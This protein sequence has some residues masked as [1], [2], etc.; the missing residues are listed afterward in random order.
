MTWASLD[1]VKDAAASWSDIIINC[2]S[3]GHNWVAQTVVRHRTWYEISQRCARG[4]GCE[5][6]ST[7]NLSGYQISGWRMA[8]PPDYLLHQKG[9][10]GQD[11]RAMLRLE[12]LRSWAQIE[13]DDEE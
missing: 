3:Y 7:I 2:R 1:A 5:R 6:L 12:S 4:C 11:G 8:Y 10:V 9:R 13:V